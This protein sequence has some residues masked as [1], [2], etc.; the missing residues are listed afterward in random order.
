VKT[1]YLHGKL[2]KRFGKKW[3]LDVDSAQEAYCAIEANTEG[4]FEYIFNS[5]RNGTE[6][7]AL[8][9]DPKH[10]KDENDL[11]EN[12]IDLKGVS[13]KNKN[14][15]IHVLNPMGGSGPAAGIFALVTAAGKLTF[16]GKVLLFVAITAATQALMKPPKP[17]ERKDP[18][19]TKSFLI[20]GG[21]T[22][23]AQ[24]I[25]VP[26]GYGRLK[27]G[28]TNVAT[29]KTSKKLSDSTKAGTLESYTEMEFVDLI[30]EGPIHGFVNKYG[31]TLN[32]D[33][34]LEGIYL[35]DV[36]VKN[37]SKSSN[38]SGT[39]NYVLNENMDTRSGKPV[40]KLGNDSDSTVL[41]EGVF[42]IKEYDNLIYGPPPYGELRYGIQGAIENDAKVMSHFISNPA[43]NEVTI[44][45]RAEISS[46]ADDGQ[47][48]ANSVA[49][50]ILI[51]RDNQDFNILEPKSS[52]C[53]ITKI[54]DGVKKVTN[55]SQLNQAI[56]EHPDYTGEPDLET[57]FY[58]TFVNASR[59][60]KKREIAQ[61]LAGKYSDVDQA[62]FELSGI[63]TSAYQFDI[64]LQIDREYPFNDSSDGATI[65][66]LKLSPEYDPSVKGGS[67]G[68]ITKTRRLQL[69]H[70]EEK[71][72]E[73]LLYPH[74]AM[75]RILVDSKN[76]SNVPD[77]SYHV[78]LK[79]VLIPSN[80]DPLSRK[81]DGPWDGL[82]KGQSGSTESI[83]SISDDN[84]Y[85]TD[86]PAWVFFDLLY[87]PRYGVGK[88][89]LEEENIDKW[90]LYKIAKHCDELVETDYAIETVSGNPRRFS[91]RNIINQ[92]T[93][94]DSIEIK[95]DP[96]EY[97]G[98]EIGT[99]Y[100]IN[101]L[102]QS[103]YD[104]FGQEFGTGESFKGKKIAFFIHQANGDMS[105]DEIAY[106]SAAREGEIQIEERV[107]ISSDPTSLSL[108]VSG[109][110][111]E[112]T[113]STTI[114]ACATQINHPIVEPRFSANLYLTD[115]AE[116]FEVIKNLASIF[117][118]MSA[119][120]AGKILA[121]QD[122][123][124]NSVQMFNNSNVSKEGFSYSGVNKNK[125]TTASMVRFNNESKHYRPDLV[126]EEDADAIQKFGYLEN[127]TMGLGITSE[128]QARRLAKWI[129]LT[130]QL[131]TE[132]VKFT[133][134]QEASY[135]FPGCVF[136]VSDET[137]V[138]KSKSGRILDIQQ[139]KRL[140]LNN[141]AFEINS[142]YLLLDKSIEN[143]PVVANVEIAVCAGISNSTVENLEQRD[144]SEISE[145][146]QDH[147]IESM[148]TPQ[149]Y[150]FDATLGVVDG[151]QVSGPQGQK[152]IAYNLL[153]KTQF[154]LDLKDNR[155]KKFEHN[156]ENGDRIIFKS[157]GVLPGGLNEYNVYY[158]TS[159]SKHTFQVSLGD[160]G[161]GLAAPV[162]II[163]IGKD[164]L[165]NPGG[166]HYYCPY[167]E[168]GGVD[169]KTQE[170]LDQ[171]SPGAT[172]SMK[173]LIGV[174]SDIEMSSS[175]LKDNLKIDSSNPQGWSMS[176]VFGLVFIGK[177]DGWIFSV[178]LNEWIYAKDI[179][180]YGLGERGWF[181]SKSLGWVYVSETGD[182]YFWYISSEQE[183]IFAK[184]NA[185]Y[186]YRYQGFTASVSQ[187]ALG[188]IS[189]KVFYVKNVISGNGYYFS[190]I[191]NSNAFETSAPG[192]TP[193]GTI[194][195]DA[196]GLRTSEILDVVSIDVDNSTQG[197]Q[198]VR[199]SLQ[200]SHGLNISKQNKISISGFV[201]DNS[202]LNTL[203]NRDNWFTVFI[204]SNTVELIDSESAAQLIDSAQ[205]TSRGSISYI[206]SARSQV[207]R[208]LEGQL[209]RLLSV[210]ETSENNYEVVGLE[211]NKSKFNAVD[212]KGVIKRPHLPIP[213]QADMSIPDAPTNLILNDLTQ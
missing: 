58:G 93:D 100:F 97:L 157:E 35:N 83:H 111:L 179:I 2:G 89:G 77:R 175:L 150:R 75:T 101:K 142:P 88:Y 202:Q 108:I 134:G 106:R 140:S 109:P 3:K 84:K 55:F 13:L 169:G 203:I 136:E 63:A 49:F 125:R 193:S 211:Y 60:L 94:P 177:N 155:I 99:S 4:F 86:N 98:E 103:E 68:G 51:T 79:K 42:Y 196:P 112:N 95:I 82:F 52:G 213:P 131:E 120:S 162:N 154:D 133:T 78:K 121:V 107:I 184:Q 30:S 160:P 70:V 199:I 188:T 41:S 151:N 192:V 85:W 191:E 148:I 161:A 208:Y 15:E 181:Y 80:Y 172:Y 206:E 38:D 69:A 37:T 27:V 67:F 96:R 117:R 185:E 1:V 200:E 19:S 8:T 12:I 201:S 182:D 174:R 212:K 178:Q 159:T 126:Y 118:G 114:G 143:D 186:F 16:L 47:V 57:S 45:F 9:K 190:F 102:T 21:I 187:G 91:C 17:P 64:A 28:A 33:D 189:N 197:K 123:I 205:I 56:T 65:K 209:F 7:I 183:S 204:N 138:G 176:S 110:A 195:S 71:I 115:R 180:V 207:E 11:R 59:A 44:S 164:D 40:Y 105:N 18:I 130:S 170:A 119:Y 152:T 116:A 50:A 171:L 132:T 122:G 137:R 165:A 72:N 90:Q 163:D 144:S 92:S 168:L 43:V 173:G 158:V 48:N 22:R 113:Y 14:K 145:D 76:F 34:I 6:Y 87:N 5:S 129:L 10:I 25:A 149:I 26:V 194:E 20:A 210:K 135:L 124:K 24:G 147:E 153:L 53:K 128:S 156:L 62:H 39:F 54:G 127:E 74:S 166:E 32:S 146:D 31:A 36:Q 23:Q 61:E 66:I 167:V 198:S 139:T 73:N 81:Y 104:L 46:Q 141:Q 29:R